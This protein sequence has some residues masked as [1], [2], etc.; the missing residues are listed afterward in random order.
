VD[1]APLCMDALGA[2]MRY[3]IGDARGTGPRTPLGTT[4]RA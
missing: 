2:S 1:L 4:R 3:G